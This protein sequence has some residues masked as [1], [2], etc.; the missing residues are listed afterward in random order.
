MAT[1][2]DGSDGFKRTQD[3]PRV[4]ARLVLA[5]VG[6]AVLVLFVFQNTE[7]ASVQF[8]FWDLDLPLAVLL[9]ATIVVTLVVAAMAA[10]Y[11]ARRS[12]KADK[13]GKR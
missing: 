9:I 1:P 4:N 5:G 6:I 11:L 2:G 10:W 7:E 13:G 3:G 12:N 8:L